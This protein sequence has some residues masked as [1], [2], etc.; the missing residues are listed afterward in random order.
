MATALLGRRPK[1]RQP[2]PTRKGHTKRRGQAPRSLR[3][4]TDASNL[5]LCGVEQLIDVLR[6]H[7]PP[8]YKVADHRAFIAKIE[9]NASRMAYG[10]YRSRGIQI[11]SGAME[12]LHR[13]ASQIRLKRPGAKWCTATA[14]A[15]INLRM[16]G[17]AERWD[18]FWGAPTLP[19][20]LTAAF[21]HQTRQYAQ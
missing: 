5:P 10:S 2:S 17:L 21:S 1:R 4:A 7:E 12:S 13:T 15:I 11:G 16:L 19:D 18:E 14:E 20:L 9:K 3:T 6:S 8:K